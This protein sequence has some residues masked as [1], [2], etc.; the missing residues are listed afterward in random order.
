MYISCSAP[1][2]LQFPAALHTSGSALTMHGVRLNGRV[3]ASSATIAASQ[4]SSPEGC[5]SYLYRVPSR[6]LA[7]GFVLTGWLD[8][9]AGRGSAAAWGVG[10][11]A[12]VEVQ[13]GAT[14]LLP[15]LLPGR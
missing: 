4:V 10:E 14:R 2:A 12:S 6:A 13:L 11:M 8:L 7:E 9:V 1:S 15:A 5:A 3:L